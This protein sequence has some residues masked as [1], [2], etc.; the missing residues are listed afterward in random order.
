MELKVK[1][2][3]SFTYLANKKVAKKYSQSAKDENNIDKR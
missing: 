3:K 1:D 2:R